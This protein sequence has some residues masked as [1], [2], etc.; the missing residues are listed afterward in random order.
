MMCPLEWYKNKVLHCR[1]YAND[2]PFLATNA[3]LV[4]VG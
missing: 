2:P 3:E 1:K 4:L